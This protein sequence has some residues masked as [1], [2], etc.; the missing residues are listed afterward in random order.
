MKERNKIN[1]VTREDQEKGR[2][3]SE[4]NSSEGN[5]WLMSKFSLL[6]ILGC[7]S[8]TRRILLSHRM[9]DAPKLE[10]IVF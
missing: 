10:S 9:I 6:F 4:S 5:V 1:K 2:L 7:Q 3:L 8:A